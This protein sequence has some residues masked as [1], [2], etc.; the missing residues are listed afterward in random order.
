VGGAC[1]FTIK[2]KTFKTEMITVTNLN[3]LKQHQKD[4]EHVYKKVC[5]IIDNS[6]SLSWLK[7]KYNLN[8]IE[9]LKIKNSLSKSHFNKQNVI[10]KLNQL[11]LK[12]K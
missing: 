5:D 3:L 6:K 1:G 2:R 8:S 7:T 9:L 10:E 12:N 11:I 4:L